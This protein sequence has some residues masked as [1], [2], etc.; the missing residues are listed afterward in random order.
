[1]R[2]FGGGGNSFS[3]AA[4]VKGHSIEEVKTA[5]M[6]LLMPCNYLNE[7][8]ISFDK[9]PEMKLKLTK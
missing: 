2:Y 9:E 8:D 5:L 4:Q 1:M 7:T 6:N 3:A